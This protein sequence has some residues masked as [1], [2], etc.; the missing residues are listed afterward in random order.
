MRKVTFNARD[1]QVAQ[2][3]A[4]F[5]TGYGGEVY[6]DGVSVDVSAVQVAQVSAGSSSVTI[7][8]LPEDEGFQYAIV[9]TIS[10]YRSVIYYPLGESD[11][12]K[13]RAIPFLEDGQDVASL[14]LELL[15][16]GVDVPGLL[17]VLQ[18]PGEDPIV[19]GFP[20]TASTTGFF[21]LL[22][23]FGP[24][25]NQVSYAAHWD[26]AAAEIAPP[27]TIGVD[28]T[29]GPRTW[30]GTPAYAGLVLVDGYQID[31]QATRSF[32]KPG[33]VRNV[34]L[35]SGASYAQ[36][37]V[38]HPHSVEDLTPLNLSLALFAQTVSDHFTLA[39]LLS[40][41][42]E[43]WVELPI[44]ERW[45][46]RPDGRTIFTLSRPTAGTVVPM[47]AGQKYAPEARISDYP[48]QNPD[49]DTP[50]TVIP[51]G[52]PSS[53]EIVINPISR[54]TTVQTADLTAEETGARQL[55]VKHWPLRRQVF[56]SWAA[57]ETLPQ[58]V[59]QGLNFVESIEPVTYEDVVQPS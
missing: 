24:A 49:T 1:D 28:G 54:S 12:L 22:G 58:R 27:P 53:G 52:I 36:R 2:V 8:V 32:L 42:F 44:E 35:L 7:S 4:G 37:L 39:E 6:K 50:L 57:E 40:K 18:T 19:S 55:I 47:Q 21:D 20:V 14:G 9:L 51:S 3:A 17:V 43:M 41:S 34:R 23:R 16:D 26:I 33:L 11:F 56:R 31:D 46:I 15:E 10:T 30:L 59:L 13:H 38:A 25:G 45:R 5:V 29:R 48:L